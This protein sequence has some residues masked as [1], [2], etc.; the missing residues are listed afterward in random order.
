MKS[1]RILRWLPLLFVL[2]LTACSQQTSGVNA[3]GNVVVELFNQKPEITQQ[4][5]EVATEFETE[6]PGTDIIIT[7]IG[8]G[9]GAAGLQ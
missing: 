5:E 9:E 3:E 7:T 6:N 1:V 4:L 2:I 8:S